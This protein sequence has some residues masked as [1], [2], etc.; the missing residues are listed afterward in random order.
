MIIIITIVMIMIIIMI[1]TIII[2]VS[3]III[4]INISVSRAPPPAQ[5][6]GKPASVSCMNGNVP[7]TSAITD[8]LTHRTAATQHLA[9][10]F[11][12]LRMLTCSHKIWLTS[13]LVSSA[14]CAPTSWH[15]RLSRAASGASD[16][17]RVRGMA[18][19]SGMEW[20]V[21]EAAHGGHGRERRAMRL[22]E[23]RALRLLQRIARGVYATRTSIDW[24][25]MSRGISERRWVQD[26][27][28]LE[29]TA[30]PVVQRRLRDSRMEWPIECSWPRRK[31][32]TGMRHLPAE[33][34]KGALEEIVPPSAR[35]R[36]CLAFWG[37]AGATAKR[38]CQRTCE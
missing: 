3:I 38:V 34:R 16:A 22:E 30:H 1:M 35:R 18:G 24:T 21:L 33:E 17:S 13:S 8:A 37:F 9:G 14:A 36:G 15:P 2:I 26:R 6:G 7:F 5:L 4:I 25:R 20:M 32:W 23:K 27:I 11:A 19:R 28:L 31:V 29:R 10:H 12:S